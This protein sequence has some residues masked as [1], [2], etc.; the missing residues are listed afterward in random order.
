MG[1]GPWRESR[2][3]A[4]SFRLEHNRLAALVPLLVQTTDPSNQSAPVTGEDSDELLP[5]SIQH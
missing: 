4:A 1:R 2:A 5:L 3:V